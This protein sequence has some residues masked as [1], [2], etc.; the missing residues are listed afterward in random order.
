MYSCSG[1][2]ESDKSQE[3]LLL[4]KLDMILFSTLFLFPNNKALPGI[5]HVS[6][7]CELLHIQ[8]SPPERY[9]N[10]QEYKNINSNQKQ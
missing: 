5:C 4:H 7:T 1:E 2:E 6:Q 10:E 3:D 8:H 9:H